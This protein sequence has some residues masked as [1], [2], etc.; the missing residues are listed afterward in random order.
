M[1]VSLSI[2][3]AMGHT[4][5]TFAAAVESY[6]LARVGHS[7]TIGEPAPT[8]SIAGIEQLV[9]RIPP[10]ADNDERFET[11]YE[12]I[13]DV[14]PPP[15]PPTLDEKKAAHLVKVNELLQKAL[16]DTTPALKRRLWE[17]LYAE[18]M[19]VPEPQR[20]ADQQV[21]MRQHEGRRKHE[22]VLGRHLAVLE[23]QID[24]LTAET[25]DAWKPAPFD[26]LF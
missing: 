10:D 19:E 13:N 24:D 9:V 26:V 21:F 25:V 3:Q 16:T 18:A 4:A 22:K 6:R 12:I 2:I 11:R 14:P 7:Q 1:K 8:P 20:T 17:H 15:A 23:S 5:E